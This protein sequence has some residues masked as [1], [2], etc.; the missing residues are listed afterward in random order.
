[1]STLIGS[2]LYVIKDLPWSDPQAGSTPHQ[3]M[4][5]NIQIGRRAVALDERDHAGVGPGVEIRVIASLCRMP[6]WRLPLRGRGYPYH[7]AWPYLPRSVPSF[8]HRTARED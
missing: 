4:Q 1:M 2:G 5:M 8:P 3:A 6:C 7:E